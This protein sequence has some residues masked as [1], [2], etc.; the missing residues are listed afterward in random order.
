MR[1]LLVILIIG[2]SFNVWSQKQ[3]YIN[4]IDPISAAVGETVTI[5]GSGFPAQAN[6][7]VA[8][9]SV[10]AS[11]IQATSTVIEVKV[12]AAAT[13]D[14]VIVTDISSGL[15]S[16]SSQFFGIKWGSTTIPST[17]P[18]S[19]ATNITTNQTQPYDLCLCDFDGDGLNDVALTAI[20]NSNTGG[21]KRLI[22]KNTSSG[23]T[24]SFSQVL[25][26]RNQPAI[27]VNC[28]DLD[29]DGKP[30]LLV[31]EV[32]GPGNSGTEDIELY[33]NSSSPGTISF[34]TEPT[35]TITPS[36]DSDGNLRDP[37]SIEVADIDLDGKPDLIV[38]FLRGEAVDIYK[39]NSVKGTLTFST[40]PVQ[41]KIS[42]GSIARGLKVS[43][44][45]RDNLADIVVVP[46]DESDVFVFQN[47]STQSGMTF[48]MITITPSE[49]NALVLPEIADL[50]NDGYPE[51]IVTDKNNNA[52]GEV[53][54]N[55]NQTAGPGAPISFSPSTEISI[56]KDPFGLST[57]DIDGDGDIDLA[58]GIIDKDIKKVEILLNNSSGNSFSFSRQQIT[59]SDNSR[60]IKIGD[61]N[62]DAKPDVLF[63]TGSRSSTT[64]FLSYVI[65]QGCI[66]PQITSPGGEFCTGVEYLMEATSGEQ[67]T[68]NW[69]VDAGSGYG[70]V[71]ANGDNFL[72]IST[73]SSNVKVKVTAT[74]NDGVCSV[75]S[76]ET[77]VALNTNSPNTPTISAST[78]TICQ[79]N[80]FTLSSS[81][82]ADNYQW[83][84]PN[85]FNSTASTITI[86]NPSA[87]NSGSYNLTVSNDN[88]CNSAKV[89]TLIEVNPLP[90]PNIANTGL[91]LFCDGGSTTLKTTT[92]PGFTYQWRQNSNIISGQTSATL[93]VSSSGG[94]AMSV[95]DPTTSCVYTT[96]NYSII[97]AAPPT[98]TI[99]AVAQICEDVES[100][101]T[102]LVAT[103]QAGLA[104]NYAWNFT[105]QAGISVGTASGNSHTISFD[106]ADTY[107][108]T[109]T[110]GYE[111]ISNCSSNTSHDIVVSASPE[112]DITSES[113][114]FVKCRVDSLLLTL[115]SDLTTYNWSTGS[116]T[117]STY[118]VTNSGNSVDISVDWSTDIGCTGTSNVTVNNYTNSQ[119]E[120]TTSLETEIA[121]NQLN[122]PAGTRSIPLIAN[123]GTDYHWE[124]ATQFDDSLGTNVR[125]FP[126]STNTEVTLTGIDNNECPE[127]ATL[128]I[129]NQNVIG[130]KSFSPNGDGLGFECWEILNSSSMTDC[131]LFVFDSRGKNIIKSTGPFENDCAWDGNDQ[132]GNPM[133]TGVYYF[134]FKCSDSNSTS[135]SI[136]LAR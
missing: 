92:F 43:D 104:T 56:N 116:N 49:Q 101:F 66:A 99:Q 69:Q 59:N 132:N 135:G 3:P 82:S 2:S 96:D 121:N 22:Y 119:L 95:T 23:G 19:A 129:I 83:T 15:S 108:A 46:T 124:P 12:P 34:P 90:L 24:A 88:G 33:L 105:N 85:D 94:Y 32:N 106:P 73:N 114:E 35:L 67:L 125:F 127:S 109:L 70:S 100:E 126:R 111:D 61:I 54:I 9:G 38:S 87:A 16:K 97:E 25:A 71:K 113:G 6:L 57:G 115:P 14:H 52:I 136:L 13:Y 75:E 44:L 50:N 11:I 27:N 39:N 64:G 79:G 76:G 17:Y 60:Y 51:I 80:P 110:T 7:S 118:A 84:G 36:R 47:T 26:L 41:L 131:T 130:R 8:F 31:S 1:R 120:I 72:D 62:G 78:A 134:V 68:Y 122:V 29:G 93:S 133:A 103:G 102:A 112:V 107:T 55:L 30:E 42:T 128:A 20:E 48:D 63:T 4:S 117:S 28:H 98:S 53:L 77:S 58:V 86:N 40:T 81:V 123:G 89:S 37:A 10:N 21:A 18:F 5:A 74:S 91:D 65:N 45:N